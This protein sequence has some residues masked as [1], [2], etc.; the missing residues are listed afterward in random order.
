MA[1][2]GERRMLFDTRGRRKNVIRVVYAVLALLMGTSLF[3]VVGPFNLAELVGGNESGSATRIY[4]EE[5]ERIEERLARNPGDEALLQRLTRAR[6]SGGNSR[7]DVS[8]GSERP[9][10]PKAAAD[11]FELAL[12]SWQRYL[13]QAGGDPSPALAQLIAATFFQLAESDNSVRAA[14]EHVAVA[15]EAQRIAAQQ[16]PSVN[17]L[18]T[19]AIYEYFDGNFKAGDRV[20]RRAAAKA[21]GKAAAKNVEEQLDEFR[22]NAKQFEQQKQQLAKAEEQLGQGQQ[23]NPFELPGNG[24][25]GG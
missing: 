9:D 20:K 25:A 2:D 19:L 8:D 18:S 7:I 23:G 4:E 3:L 5:A 1:D 13:E 10:V 17:A 21:G 12:E 22:Q 24:A 15:T 16:Q 6:I 14:E 11:E